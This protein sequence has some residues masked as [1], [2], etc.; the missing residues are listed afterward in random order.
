MRRCDPLVGVAKVRA[1]AKPRRS[2]R[3]P[4]L[5]ASFVVYK[6]EVLLNISE[7]H[8]CFVGV[9]L[10]SLG[11]AV[12]ENRVARVPE[13]PHLELVGL[14]CTLDAFPVDLVDEAVVS[15]HAV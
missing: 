15:E 10:I 14:T 9:E 7:G 2:E 6:R 3:V 8:R 4:P 11:F 13:R 5:V 1:G 12:I